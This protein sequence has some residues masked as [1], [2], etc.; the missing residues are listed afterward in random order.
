MAVIGA[1][2]GGVAWIAAA[3]EGGLA[4][5]CWGRPPACY[6]IEPCRRCAVLQVQE[7]QHDL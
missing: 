6:F 4:D 5:D 2:A 7:R 1:A 3:E